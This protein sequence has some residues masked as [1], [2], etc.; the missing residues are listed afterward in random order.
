MQSRQYYK[1]RIIITFSVVTIILV[2]VLSRVGYIFISNLYLTQLTEQVNIVTKL[3]SKEID[4][5]YLDVLQLGNPTSTTKEYFKVLF[6]K[7]LDTLLHSEIF[8]FDEEFKVAVHSDTSFALGSEEP[9]LSINQK[10][11]EELRVNEASAS[12]PFKGD[13]GNWY[14][15]GFYRL[16][17]NYWLAV[18]ESAARFE[19][20]DEFSR[21]FWY[22]G[23]TGILISVFAGW[24]MSRSITKPL[25]KLV[26]FSSE[27]GKGNFSAIHPEKMHGEIALLADAMDDMKKD[28]SENQKERENLLA[29]IAHE[30]RNP[31]G[32]IE[33]LVN[34][35]K[36]NQSSD[37]KNKEYLERILKEVNGLKSLINSF[38][39]YSRPV[40]TNPDWADVNKISLEIENIFKSRLHSENIELNCNLELK[41]IWFDEG[42]LRNVLLNLVSNSLDS[43]SGG[44]NILIESYSKNGN[45]IISV[46]DSG[47]GISEENLSLVF[48]PFFTT[49]KDGTGLGLAI[50]KKL[51]KENKADLIASNNPD[52]SGSTFMIV[53]EIKNE[54]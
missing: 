23:L 16:N 43:L 36:E 22:I 11:I 2:I 6:Q 5:N 53:K 35:V 12:M 39:N 37:E 42:H 13:D 4:R 8:V 24:L 14:L 44:G 9:R 46:K 33:L 47:S 30:I 25:N 54:S 29:Q 17:G 28:L 20:V 48:N 41:K 38:L 31:L 3:I 21:T 27:I 18:R 40:E 50:S 15:W 1:I 49:K 52:S 7:N 51:C 34:L 45:W 26:K 10:E 32:G 19:K